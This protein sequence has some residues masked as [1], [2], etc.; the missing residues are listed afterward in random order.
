VIVALELEPSGERVAATDPHALPVR[1]YRTALR[2]F[3]RE[4]FRAALART[5]GQVPAAARLLRLPEST[6][7]YRAGKAGV[8]RPRTAEPKPDS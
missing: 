3:D 1:P 4:L 6:F 7:R 5:G 8:L 2:A